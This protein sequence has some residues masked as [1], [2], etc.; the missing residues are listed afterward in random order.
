MPNQTTPMLPAVDAA[1][2][3]LFQGVYGRVFFHKL[4]QAGFVPRTEAQAQ[5]MLKVAQTVREAEEAEAIKTASDSNDPYA[6]AYHHLEQAVAQRGLKLP[7]RMDAASREYSF[8]QAAAA[9][10]SDP[11]IYDSVLAVKAAEAEY[12]LTQLTPQK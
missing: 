8:K 7:G 2:D 11:D 9:L 10:A 1:A 4:A 3:N 12:Y 6:A 5:Y